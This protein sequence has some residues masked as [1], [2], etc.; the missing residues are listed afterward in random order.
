MGLAPGGRRPARRARPLRRRA[1]SG[2]LS[3]FLST[4]ARGRRAGR[5]AAG[6]LGAR[7]AGAR[8]RRGRRRSRRGTPSTSRARW[9]CC[10]PSPGPRFGSGQHPARRPRSAPKG[11]PRRW[12]QALLRGSEVLDGAGR[13]LRRASGAVFLAGAVDAER[14]APAPRRT[15]QPRC[16]I[17]RRRNGASRRPRPRSPARWRAS[18]PPRAAL[19]SAAECL[20]CRPRGRAAGGRGARGDAAPRRLAAARTRRPSEQQLDR[21]R[22]RLVAGRAPG[23]RDRARCCRGAG[24]RARAP[25]EALGA[26][27]RPAAGARGRAGDGAGAAGPLAGAGG[28][29]GGA[30]PRGGGACS[31]A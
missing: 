2:P 15:R 6:R 3:D 23:G 11:R 8:S 27:A 28:A 24:R 29:R 13:V 31:S 18:P 22:E 20:R 19:A 10:P 1:S 25:D 21:L 26:G 17:S 14:A 16:T 4:V 12:V 9:C 5:A 30:A 7:G